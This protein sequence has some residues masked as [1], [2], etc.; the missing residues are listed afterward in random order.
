M[1]NLH[2]LRPPEGAT[3]SR[4]RVGRGPGSGKGKTAGKGHKG[5]KAR[6]GGKR[7]PWFEGGQMPLQR[8]VP[9][10]GFH[11]RSRV[12]C[13]IVNVGDLERLTE[14]IVT[15]EVLHA[16]GLVSLNRAA[17]VKL[18]GKGEVERTFTVRVH[19][20]SEGARKK[21]EAAGGTVELLD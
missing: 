12:E 8:R 7:R 18:L 10:R 9:K 15:P 17:P 20:V 13:E 21:V 6:S 4:K 1:A 16:H 3:H 14:D 11:N 19:R 5:Q 2:E